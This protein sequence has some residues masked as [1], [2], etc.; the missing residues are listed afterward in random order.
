MDLWGRWIGTVKVNREHTYCPERLKDQF[1]S[2]EGSGEYD[3]LFDEAKI[4]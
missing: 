2:G 3:F 1:Q 4:K